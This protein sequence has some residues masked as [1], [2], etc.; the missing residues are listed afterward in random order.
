MGVLEKKQYDVLASCCFAAISQLITHIKKKTDKIVLFYDQES[1]WIQTKDAV[2]I[3]CFSTRF[4]E[5]PE[6][7]H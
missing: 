2:S 7:C 3:D 6:E 4:K 5:K 1:G